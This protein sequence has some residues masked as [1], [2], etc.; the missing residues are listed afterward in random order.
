PRVVT[1][2]SGRPPHLSHPT[3]ATPPPVP[4]FRGRQSPAQNFPK[5][6]AKTHRRLPPSPGFPG[7]TRVTKTDPCWKRRQ[8][9]KQ[10]R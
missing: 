3:P 5:S 10:G 1:G 2:S 7:P 9:R 4:T 8:R 6:P